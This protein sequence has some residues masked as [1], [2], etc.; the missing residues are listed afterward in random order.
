MEDFPGLVGSEGVVISQ[1]VVRPNLSPL[2]RGFLWTRNPQRISKE[3]RGHENLYGLE[4]IL[5]PKDPR[6]FEV[7]RRTSLGARSP[8]KNLRTSDS[9]ISKNLRTSSG[10]K[11]QGLPRTRVA[12]STRR[13]RLTQD[14]R[15]ISKDPKTS[16]DP[17]DS[18]NPRKSETKGSPFF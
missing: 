2:T 1:E 3:L 9:S 14:P 15:R 7:P 13:I 18:K 5:G 8:C 4:D 16:E 11:T 6:T 12:P 17:R 10:L